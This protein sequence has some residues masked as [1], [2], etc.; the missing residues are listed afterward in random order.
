ML[1]HFVGPYAVYAGVWEKCD[2]FVDSNL[3]E[4][5]ETIE[6]VSFKSSDSVYPKKFGFSNAAVWLR[7]DFVDKPGRYVLYLDHVYIESA[8]VYLPSTNGWSKTVFGLSH[9]L[10]PP[11]IIHNGFAIEFDVTP[12]QTQGVFYLRA[13][14]KWSLFLP[15]DIEPRDLFL[16]SQRGFD[17]M[18]GLYLGLIGSL[19]VYNFLIYRSV[20]DSAYL[21]YIAT[22]LSLHL[23]S[24]LAQFGHV[25]TFIFPNWTWFHMH[26]FYMTHFLSTATI[27][28]FASRFLQ[29]KV[30]VPRAHLLL[31]IPVLFNTCLFFFGLIFDTFLID[32]FFQLSSAFFSLALLATAA[33]LS[34]RRVKLGQYFL[35]AWTSMIAFWMITFLRMDG[36]IPLNFFTYYSILLGACLEGFLLSLALADR[37][38]IL[39]ADKES[40]EKSALAL[41]EKIKVTQQV[42]HDV[43]SPLAALEV[44][45]SDLNKIDFEEIRLARRATARIRDITNDLTIQSHVGDQ[46]LLVPL[47]FLVDTI[48]SEKK[49]Q[50]SSYENLEIDWKFLP[51]DRDMFVQVELAG[52]QRILSNLIDNAVEAIPDQ[53]GKIR[54]WLLRKTKYILYIED[55]GPGI[56]LEV[57][58]KLGVEPI[59]FG[60]EGSAAGSGLGVFHAASTLQNWD[61]ELVFENGK[62]G[63]IVSVSLPR[64]APPSWFLFEIWLR[65]RATVVVVDDDPLIKRAWA[66]RLDMDGINLVYFSNPLEVLSWIS[67]GK[68]P[69]DIIFLVDYAF[70]NSELTG[71]DLVDS[72]VNV[73]TCVLV[74]SSYD[75]TNVQMMCH[76]K[77]VKLL[78]KPMLPIIPI[79]V[80]DEKLSDQERSLMVLIDND[81]LVTSSWSM[82]AKG[83]GIPLLVFESFRD[84]LKSRETIPQNARIFMDADLPGENSV[85]SRV[86]QLNSYGFHEVFIQTGH[87]KE[88]FP[89]ING[90]KGIVG[91]KFPGT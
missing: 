33:Y 18:F 27:F 30:R 68:L 82:V 86:T 72:L 62:F 37:L 84:F 63:A 58:E 42:A 5:I 71:F 40:A 4:T 57:L 8:E 2:H 80:L 73:G 17:L 20:R 75:R 70:V 43:R 31:L 41:T 11:E 26:V 22:L 44:A 60:K 38:R 28:L 3:S 6:H 16:K 13:I 21:Y 90:C 7:C 56:P 59:T 10:R 9:P 1:L 55:S 47:P 50:Y 49:I 85:E 74:T 29:L 67:Q 19:I 15:V 54:L 78:P 66:Q 32:L 79:R 51:E 83:K 24:T 64:V 89:P 23:F 81:N 77:N 76:N 53:C 45:L 69:K 61:G 88:K 91:K 65:S 34:W 25:R 12:P 52:F 87:P 14:S 35:L 36:L 39:R 48:V 46:S